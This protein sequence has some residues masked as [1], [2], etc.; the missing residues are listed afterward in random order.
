MDATAKGPRHVTGESGVDDRQY[1]SIE[2]ATTEACLDRVIGDGAVGEC[3]GAAATIKDATTHTRRGVIDDGRVVDRQ[4]AKILDAA[5]EG[6]RV[7]GNG[8]VIN[9]HHPRIPDPAAGIG[10]IIGDGA[11]TDSERTETSDA[12]SAHTNEIAI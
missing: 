1:S 10:C 6:G 8:A 4:G 12:A 5:T 7:I 2:D 11:V 9:C 3:H